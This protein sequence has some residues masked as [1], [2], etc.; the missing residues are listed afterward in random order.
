MKGLL[1]DV[2]VDLADIVVNAG[3]AK[4]KSEARRHIDQ[5]GIRLND[6]V[7][8]TNKFARLAFSNETGWLLYD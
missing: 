3:F 1:P 8:V 4:T 6:T 5:G 7:I 2:G